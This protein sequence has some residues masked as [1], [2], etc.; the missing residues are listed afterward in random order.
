M[1]TALA[2]LAVAPAPGQRP[3]T[4][5][6]G[7]FGRY[8]RFDRSLG[9]DNA[10]GGG[11]RLGVFIAP[12]LALEA[13][14]AYVETN[15][16]R[17]T[18]IKMVPINARMLYVVPLANQ[19]ALMLGAG[20]VRNN[21]TN[22]IG[23]WEDGASGLLGLRFGA[24]R[25]ALRLEAIEDYFSSPFNQG[26]GAPNNWNATVQ[27]G[28]SVLFGRTGPRDG[29]HDGV[30]DG[31]D[32][33]RNTPEG[34]ATDGRGCSLPEDFD[35]DG[36][37]DATD[38]CPNTPASD[39]VDAS[40]C[41]LPKDG[42]G[43]GII[44]AT[45]QCPNTPLYERVNANGCALDSDGDGVADAL[46][47][48]GNTPVGTMVDAKGCEL[49]KD[50]DGDGVQDPADK[51][52]RTTVGERVDAIGCPVLFLERQRR[53]VLEGVNFETASANLT[54]QSYVTLDRVAASLA[55]H[56]ELQVEVAG[57][58]DSRGGDQYNQRLSQSR[59]DAVRGYLI[60]KGVTADRLSARG[61]GE[62]DPID[63]NTTTDGLARNRRVELHRLN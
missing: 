47:Q 13:S 2:A 28:L 30:V 36:V 15:G 31:L 46:D 11:G 37:I 14:A 57:Y 8:S 29:D 16:P 45:D 10:F 17:N 3:G 54:D 40:G 62:N 44:D 38:Q 9:W 6:I 4:V 48:C 58:T 61:F 60:R 34:D 49:T 59:A 41:S 21:Y 1:I 5:E 56:P 32:A 25:V 53:I 22:T 20:Y 26:P 33:C 18:V 50:S 42:D 63:S 35:R 24:D 55:A 23:S 7:A 27:A 39:R 12:G 43:D 51:C 19:F 52:P